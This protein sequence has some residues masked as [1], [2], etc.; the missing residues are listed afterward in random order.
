[1]L[2]SISLIRLLSTSAGVSLLHIP[3]KAIFGSC[4][5]QMFNSQKFYQVVSY[6][7]LDWCTFSPVPHRHPSHSRFLL[8]VVFS[9]SIISNSSA[10]PWTGS[11]LPGFSAHEIL[12]ASILEWVAMPSSRGSSR[13]RDW[14]SA[15][16]VVNRF[17]TYCLSHQRRSQVLANT[18]C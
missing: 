14:T 8:F 16:C 5:M 17:F 15:S 12:Q 10:T 2:M 9:C 1:M 4:S 18:S 13:P 7:E 3:R 6:K 11:S